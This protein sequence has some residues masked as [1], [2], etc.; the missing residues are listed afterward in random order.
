MP[1]DPSIALQIKNP[2]L[3]SPINQMAKIYEIKQAQ[4]ANELNRLKMDEYTRGVQ[5]Q[6]AFKNALRGAGANDEEAIKNA[7]FSKGDVKGYSDYLKSKGDITKT[8]VE[9][10]SLKAKHG[11]QMFRDLSRNPS[12]AN[13][14]AHFEDIQQS[15]LYTPQEKA[16][17]QSKLEQVMQMTVEERRAYLA[18]QGASVSELKPSIQS[19]DIGGST[20]MLSID[21]FANTSKLVAGSEAT[22]TATPGDIMSAT[23]TRRGQ[24]LVNTRDL[25]KIEIEK[26]K[27]SPE[28]IT[29]KAKMETQGKAQAK[30]EAAAPEAISKADEAIRKIDELV[31]TEPTKTKEGKI[32]AGTKPHPGFGQAVGAGLPGLRY[33]P[34]TS[35]ADFDARLKEIQGGAFLEAYNTLKGGGSITEVEGQKATQAITRMSL[36]Q[37]EKEFKAAARE[38]QNILRKG[39]ERSKAKLGNVGAPA[40]ASDTPDVD[41]T[42]PLLQ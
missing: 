20:R 36:A 42:N 16:L 14:Q 25:Q 24:D 34:G 8:G 28:Y 5:E 15:S 19:Q 41:T 35:A 6:E 10:E 1:I 40:A 2:P 21:P 27:M 33:V 23:T 9:N 3:E 39:I 32:I 22:K 13:V 11:A 37:S 18:S 31:G 26:G 4:Q 29:M 12:N 17:A 30:F 7:F 38:F